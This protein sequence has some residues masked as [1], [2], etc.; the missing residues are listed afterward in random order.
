[1]IIAQWAVAM[2]TG[3][4]IA[5]NYH[6]TLI[7]KPW[8]RA[9][10]WQALCS[11]A[12]PVPQVRKM[13]W[14]WKSFQHPLFC[15]SVDGM[16]IESRCTI[17]GKIR[18]SR[19]EFLSELIGLNLSDAFLLILT[20]VDGRWIFL[21]YVFA[22]KGVNYKCFP[23]EHC[24][25]LTVTY[26]TCSNKRWYHFHYFFEGDRENFGGR[27]THP[28]HIAS[29]DDNSSNV[30]K[31]LLFRSAD[32]KL[33]TFAACPLSSL[34]SFSVISLPSLSNKGQWNILTTM[35]RCRVTL[36]VVCATWC[37]SFTHSLDEHFLFFSFLWD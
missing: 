11:S 27:E 36:P 5:Q 6:K 2:V 22:S 32:R 20:I 4:S 29:S 3:D 1:M 23:R 10:F 24:S 21:G 15:N 8:L 35:L 18:K 17:C 37:L 25:T 12:E 14:E 33:D 7:K 34:P 30:I 19:V 16:W 31:L 13:D 26:S 28:S 9:P